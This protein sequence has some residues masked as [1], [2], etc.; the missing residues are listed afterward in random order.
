MLSKA[1]E[2]FYAVSAKLYCLMIVKI[3]IHLL[4]DV[5]MIN[6][7]CEHQVAEMRRK[8]EADRAKLLKENDAEKMEVRRQW[9]KLNDE[10]NRMEHLHNLQQ[11]KG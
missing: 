8:V 9:Q 6:I 3:Y 5:L 2:R 11:V 4:Y 1:T 10:V 7:P